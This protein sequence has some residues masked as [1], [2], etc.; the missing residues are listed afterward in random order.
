MAGKKLNQSTDGLKEIISH[1]IPY[2]VRMMRQTYVMLSDGSAC[3][4]LSQTIINALIESFSIHARSLI[5]FF[6]GKDSPSG[7]MAYAKHFAKDGYEPCSEDGPG[8]SFKHKLNAQIAHPSYW[9]TSNDEEKLSAKDRAALMQFVEG[10]L[11]RLSSTMKE[12]FKPHWPEDMVPEPRSELVGH[13]HVL[14]PAGATGHIGMIGPVSISSATAGVTG[15]TG[16]GPAGFGTFTYSTSPK[17][18]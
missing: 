18:T 4:W 9:R 12:N 11:V 16:P 5:E 15:P 17:S 1:H 6:S 3:L 10:E 8:V 13:V 14:G 7:G 2:E